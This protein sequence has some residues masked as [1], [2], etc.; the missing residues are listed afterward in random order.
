MKEN[1]EKKLEE[2]ANAIIKKENPTMEEIN[3]IVFM[4]NRIE[5][6]ENSEAAKA[7]KEKS[8]KE[9]KERMANLIG[10]TGGV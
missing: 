3:F 6:K 5:I 8:D 10:M 4:L 2:F 9:W 7:D 1:I